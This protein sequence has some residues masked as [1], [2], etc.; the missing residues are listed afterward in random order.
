MRAAK[1][2]IVTIFVVLLVEFLGVEIFMRTHK[3]SAKEKPSWLEGTF[4]QHARNISVPGDA[5]TLKNPRSVTEEIMAEAREHW[6]EHCAVCHGLDGRG[7]SVFGSRMYP[8]V[9]DMTEAGTQQKADGELFYIISNG[10]RL[11]GMPAWEGEDQPDELWDLVSF[12]RHL[13]QLSPE[14]LKQMKE[15]A[16]EG[17]GEEESDKT[18]PNEGEKS[19]AQP[20][21]PHKDK[22]GAKPHKH[23][24]EH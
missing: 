2:V 8:P 17:K 3:F 23:S 9:P 5:K 22:P 19:A 24:H 6:T 12:I 13:P 16:G 1:T 20:V 18:S 4:A 21:K 15:L 14:E 11:T 7:D 10:V